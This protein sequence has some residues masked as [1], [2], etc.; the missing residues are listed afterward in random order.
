[1]AVDIYKRHGL[2]KLYLGFYST[3][4]RESFLGVY[5]GTYDTLMYYA[6]KNKYPERISN[7]VAGGIA[8]IAVWTSMYPIDYAK[9][10]IQNDSLSNPQFK[11]ATQYLVSDVKAKGFTVMFTCFPLMMVRA[12]VANAAGF[13]AF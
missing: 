3:W 5:F 8:G 11:S 2:R 12:F 7:L 6:R 9:T 1:M 10:R 4:L 13:L